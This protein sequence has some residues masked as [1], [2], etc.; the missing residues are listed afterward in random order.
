LGVPVREI[1]S[2]VINGL[3]DRLNELRYRRGA[4][5]RSWRADE[6]IAIVLVL[7]LILGLGALAAVAVTRSDGATA[8]GAHSNAG[9]V[10]PSVRPDAGTEVITETVKRGG[11]TVR[12]VR[13]RVAHGS[14]VIRTVG[15]AP[16]ET[17]YQTQTVTTR[18]IATVTDLQQVTVTAAPETIT[19]IETVTCKPKDC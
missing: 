4:Q 18:E 1:V 12:V 14:V 17:I 5:S 13:H 11:T 2:R 3:H 6:G 7:G 16:S 19:V 10:P 15:S 8:D 9:V